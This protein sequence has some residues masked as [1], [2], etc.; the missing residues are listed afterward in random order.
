M[1]MPKGVAIQMQT[2]KVLSFHRVRNGRF[3]FLF[4][5][6][7]LVIFMADAGATTPIVNQK[8]SGSIPD[9]ADVADFKISPNGQTAVFVAD[10]ET[11][12]AFELYSVPTDGLAD[13]ILLSSGL[14]P[15]G[16]SIEIFEIS[17]DSSR[18]VY[19]AEQDSTGVE[20]LY[21]VPINGGP[22]VKLNPPITAVDGNV[23]LFAISPDSSRVVLMVDWQTNGRYE[24]FSLP[25]AGGTPLR[26]NGDLPPGYAVFDFKLSPDNSRVVYL[27]RQDSAVL[28][29]YAV[30]LAGGDNYRLNEPLVAGGQVLN[31]AISP[32]SSRVVY[33]A[34]QETQFVQELYSVPLANPLADA[35]KLNP[36]LVANGDVAYYMLEISPDSN[37]IA[38]LADQDTDGIN[39]LY[40]VPLGGG[41]AVKL[42][43]PLAAGI[44]P[45][46][47]L[48]SH[49]FRFS[50]DSSRVVYSAEQDRIGVRE[51]YS[52]V[53]HTGLVTKLNDTVIP[54]TGDVNSFKISPDGSRV[55]FWGNVLI[56]NSEELFTVPIRG[57]VVSKLN[58]ALPPL[59]Y[60]ATYAISPD[61][62]RVVYVSTQQAQNVTEIY[63]VPL[64]D[65]SITKLNPPLVTGGQVY[66]NFDISPDSNRVFYRAEQEVDNVAEL[67]VSANEPPIV[68]F[69]EATLT[70]AESAAT[71]MLTVELSDTILATTTVD[72]AVTG[73]TAVNGTDYTLGADTLTFTPGETEQQIKV[74]I[75]DDV[76]AEG[77]ETAVLT[78]TDSQNGIVGAQSAFTLTI[79]DNEVMPTEMYTIY[80]PM[81][82]K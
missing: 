54:P 72:Y 12:D 39:E 76:L 21:S 17:P 56:G 59:G 36:P 42:N 11:N 19:V 50:P 4:T 67:F 49:C 53:L 60:V 63:S 43:A 20:E 3:A 65:G 69:Q 61:S 8:L 33:V 62:Q 57:G 73:G 1:L 79:Q 10:L 58:S 81:I 9:T 32:D 23:E 6:L 47:C 38:Y 82:A 14:L 48:W 37:H 66:I 31:F 27:A 18:V 5:L 24:L 41:T 45:G 80:L 40:S 22:I 15:I 2:K 64:A 77:D 34:D 75:T 55:V 29:L 71:V 74:L 46:N 70:V 28:E 26:L 68:Q 25:I 51:L 35:T 30:P 52:V 78:L 16:T 13:P 44:D 7:L